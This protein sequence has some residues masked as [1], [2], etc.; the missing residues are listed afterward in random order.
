MDFQVQ[1]SDPA[2]AEFEEILQ[3]SF[4]NFPEASAER[5]GNE[6]LD[7]LDLLKTFPYIG[8]PVPNRPGL[9]ELVHTPILIYYSVKESPNVVEILH[10]WNALRGNPRF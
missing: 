2:L 8:K 6:L 1:I 9:R 7:H 4:L 10:F 5:F 3:Y